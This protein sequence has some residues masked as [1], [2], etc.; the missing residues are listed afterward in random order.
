MKKLTLYILVLFSKATYSQSNITAN[1]EVAYKE[2][3]SIFDADLD[4]DSTNITISTDQSR[5]FVSFYDENINSTSKRKCRNI[6]TTKATNKIFIEELNKEKL[7]QNISLH[8]YYY[9]ENYNFNNSERILFISVNFQ[10]GYHSE[11]YYIPLKKNSEIEKALEIAK[12][13][14]KNEKCFDKLDKKSTR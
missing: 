11:D 8:G 4:D 3:I 9:T 7:I 2:L 1:Q 14:F 5:F 6:K 10:Y 12:S 13:I